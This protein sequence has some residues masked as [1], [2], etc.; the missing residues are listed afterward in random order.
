M[1]L[2]NPIAAGEHASETR[3]RK[4]RSRGKA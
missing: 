3:K 1:R 4:M 2:H